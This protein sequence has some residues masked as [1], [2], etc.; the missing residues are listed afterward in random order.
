MPNLS[1]DAA[2]AFADQLRLAR[3]SAL[4]DAQ[5]FDE[6][7]HAVER[8]GSYLT[9]EKFA[10]LG[11]AGGLYKYE[12]ALRDLASNSGLAYALDD[13]HTLTSFDR[14]YELVRIARNDAMHQGAFARHLTVHAIELAIILEDALTQLKNP[15]VGDFMVRNPVCAE[16]WQPVGFIRQQMLANSYSCLPMQK[17]KQWYLISDAAI[18]IYLGAR[19]DGRERRKLLA[20]TL[21]EAF[22]KLD[23]KPIELKLDS[24][25]LA[26]ALE[27]LR[28]A[29]VLLIYRARDQDALAGLLT[30]FDLL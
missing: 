15:V 19:R 26:D 25:P 12:G 4:G 6:I 8:L 2:I 28:E 11:V 10:D 9:K 5:E 22:P 20:S 18:A 1:R 21:E 23:V 16:T 29:P 24:T 30:A 17:G 3:H 14:L 27:T 13:Q 7:I